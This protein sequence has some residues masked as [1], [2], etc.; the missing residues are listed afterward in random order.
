MASNAESFC[1][2]SFLAIGCVAS[3]MAFVFMFS[4]NTITTMEVISADDMV[5]YIA[6]GRKYDIPFDETKVD[7][8]ALQNNISFIQI[9]YYSTKPSKYIVSDSAFA[10]PAMGG[11]IALFC[12]GGFCMCMSCICCIG[13]QFFNDT[14]SSPSSSNRIIPTS[15]IT[16][17]TME[18]R[19]NSIR[20]ITKPIPIII[21]VVDS[22]TP[23]TNHTLARDD[24][25]KDKILVVVNP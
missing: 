7:E 22:Q 13:S 21:H 8:Y 18:T 23:L 1:I 6:N 2:L 14:P 16:M 3:V 11:I 25:N 19:S 15:E 10:I 24:K 12:V 5:E 4:C 17:P 20:T 9:C